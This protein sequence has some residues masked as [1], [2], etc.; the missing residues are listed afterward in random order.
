MKKKICIC[1]ALLLVCLTTSSLAA[2]Y[3][4]AASRTYDFYGATD[5]TGTY[6]SD[7]N[8]G[9][10]NVVDF[11]DPLFE[12]A[13]ATPYFIL[14]PATTPGYGAV[15]NGTA[16]IGRFTDVSAVTRANGII[17]TLTIPKL[18]IAF[19]IVEGTTTASMNQGVGHFEGTSAWEGNVNLAGHNRG[20]L[21]NIGSI[22]N[23]VSGDIIQYTT[24]LGT[25]TY[26]VTINTT[27]ANN[28][29]SYLQPTMDNR[30]TLITCLAD[31]PEVRI[32]VQGV[33]IA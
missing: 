27:I 6:G 24:A 20:A 8:Y 33:E 26:L 30:I 22:K 15:S 11:R 12:Q 17:G 28:D 29:W 14:A 32:C 13:P 7:Y 2:D 31:R 10:T 19:P 23:L 16:G 25:K 3:N 18:G 21:Y 5:Y 4:F 1:V 9:Q